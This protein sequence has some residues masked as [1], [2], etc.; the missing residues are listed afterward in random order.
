MLLAPKSPA[1]TFIGWRPT[2]DLGPLTG[3]TSKRGKPVWFLKSPPTTPPTNWQLHRRAFFKV[4]ADHWWRIGPHRR[5][6]WLRAARLAHL[7]I[8]GYNLFTYYQLTRDRAAIATV[9]QQTA[10]QL[11]DGP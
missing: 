8:T 3:Y 11:L 9:E 7:N 1:L 2:G 5:S 4:A 10:I 6:D